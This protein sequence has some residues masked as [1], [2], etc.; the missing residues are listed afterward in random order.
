MEKMKVLHILHEIYPSGAEMMIYNA[1]PYWNDACECT[2]MATGS[3]SGP[4]AKQMQNKGYTVVHVPT[5]GSGKKAKLAHLRLFWKYM[6]NNSFDVIHIHRES[7]AFEYALLAHLAG[8]KH[9]CRTVHNNFPHKGLQRK[10]KTVTRSFMRNMLHVPFVAICD[11]VAEN[12]KRV[13]NNTC[14]YTIYNWCDNSKYDF[15]DWEEK[16]QEKEKRNLADKLVLVS[17]GNCSKVKNHTLLIEAISKMK[18]KECVHYF[19]VGFMEKETKEEEMLAETLGIAKQITFLGSTDPMP[20]L[21]AADVY[22]MPSLFEGL[23]IA[24][25]EAVFTGMPML[26]AESP[27][28]VEFQNKGF[29]NV[30][31]FVPTEENLANALDMC[32]MKLKEGKLRPDLAQKQRAAELYDCEMQVH[33][34]V[35]MYQKMTGKCGGTK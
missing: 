16:K 18:N 34:Y 32:A 26:L 10:I 5:S 4:F 30:T 14:A 21:K 33:K 19:H 31:Y 28:L 25:L 27:G 15:L 17:V 23:S 8:N 20:Y 3:Q 7:L 6:K 1:Y 13:F 11:G 22:V 12:E 9:V 35:Q 2:I 24:A 29:P